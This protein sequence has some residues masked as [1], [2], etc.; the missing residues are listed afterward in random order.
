MK[1]G[2]IVMAARICRKTIPKHLVHCVKKSELSRYL[3]FFPE[4]YRELYTIIILS[5]HEFNAHIKKLVSDSKLTMFNIIYKFCTATVKTKLHV[6]EDV[7][8]E[9]PM[10]YDRYE[11]TAKHIGEQLV[12]YY[13]LYYPKGHLTDCVEFKTLC[14]ASFTWHCN[15]DP[16]AMNSLVNYGLAKKYFSKYFLAMAMT[17]IPIDLYIDMSGTKM[18]LLQAKM[19]RLPKWN[20]DLTK[21]YRKDPKTNKR[22]IEFIDAPK[23]DVDMFFEDFEA[24]LT[25][26]RRNP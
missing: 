13:R 16:T 21:L 26:A 10:W 9:V 2:K 23:A 7:M 6:Y 20:L 22:I 3:V 18:A 14:A 19:A 17:P 1:F 4:F 15:K 5:E 8:E 24:K 12:P 25:R 11:A